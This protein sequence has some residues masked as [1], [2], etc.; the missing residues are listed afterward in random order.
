[1]IGTELNTEKIILEAAEVEFLEKGYG[2]AKIMAIA[3][4]AGVSHSMLHYYFRSKQNLFRMIF[5]QKIQTLSQ[6][7][8]GINEQHLPFTDTIRFLVECQFDFVAQNPRLPFFVV[9]EII[10]DKEN[11]N[12]V[13][14]VVKPKISEIIGSLEKMLHEEI[15]K[16]AIRPINF[17]H[18]IMN[19]LSM[20]VFTFLAL[21]LL[22]TIIPHFDEETRK[23]LLNERRDSNVQFML[24]ALIP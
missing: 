14:E 23:F 17:L 2:K 15:G 3:K 21:P 11:L 19:I 1:M 7:F 6:M 20:N 16:G 5:Q 13:I 4:R 8:E 18:L 12:L 24:N 22:E 9:N 10:S